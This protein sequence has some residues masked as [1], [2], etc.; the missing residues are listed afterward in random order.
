MRKDDQT[1]RA[2]TVVGGLTGLVVAALI[3]VGDRM[4]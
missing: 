3:L 1:V 2:L 4:L